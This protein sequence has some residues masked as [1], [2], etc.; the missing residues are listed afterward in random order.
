MSAIDVDR[1]AAGR[2][3]PRDQNQVTRLRGIEGRFLIRAQGFDGGEAGV[4]EGG[5][6]L[7]SSPSADL[8]AARGYELDGRIGIGA[9]AKGGGHE[10]DPAVGLKFHRSEEDDRRVFVVRIGKETERQR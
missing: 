2:T 6:D 9:L 3:S 7:R 1:E 5:L 4:A 10:D 8:D